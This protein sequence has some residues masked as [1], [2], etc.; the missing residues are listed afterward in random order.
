MAQIDVRFALNE[1]LDSSRLPSR[2]SKVQR[3]H[4]LRTARKIEFSFRVQELSDAVRA[5]FLSGVRQRRKAV[6]GSTM[7]RRSSEHAQLTFDV[8]V[9]SAPRASKQRTTSG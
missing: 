4:S 8:S 3:R 1:K 6:L 5:A 2:R 9:R 7:L